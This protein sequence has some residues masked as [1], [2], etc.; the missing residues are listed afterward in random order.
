MSGTISSSLS[1][2]NLSHTRGSGRRTLKK[3]V[4][5]KKNDV[6]ESFQFSNS[7]VQHKK[8]EKDKKIS[9]Y[10][11][12]LHTHLKW[13]CRLHK[14][15]II[16][17]DWIPLSNMALIHK[18][19][20]LVSFEAS[21]DFKY[22]YILDNSGT[23]WRYSISLKSI[24]NNSSDYPENDSK[25]S[26][27]DDQFDNQ[28]TV[29]KKN[30]YKHIYAD[31]GYDDEELD[32]GNNDMLYKSILLNET[33][34]GRVLDK[35]D[36]IDIQMKSQK[37]LNHGDGSSL[38][39]VNEDVSEFG[40]P[41]GVAINKP[42]VSKDFQGKADGI[43]FKYGSNVLSNTDNIE[44]NWDEVLRLGT[45]VSKDSESEIPVK[46]KKPKISEKNVI[47]ESLKNITKPGDWTP[48]TGSIKSD[49]L[50][51]IKKIDG[52]R[53]HKSIKKNNKS[54]FQ[55]VFNQYGEQ[56]ADDDIRKAGSI[57]NIHQESNLD[58]MN[59]NDFDEQVDNKFF[60]T[61]NYQK[62]DTF[63]D[64]PSIFS[65]HKIMKNIE[66]Q[67]ENDEKLDIGAIMDEEKSENPES[68]KMSN[69]R[70]ESKN[71]E[72]KSITSAPKEND[73]DFKEPFRTSKKKIPTKNTE[74][75][76]FINST[77]TQQYKPALSSITIS[78]DNKFILVGLSSGHLRQYSKS[79][80][81]IHIYPHKFL[82]PMILKSTKDGKYFFIGDRSG[83]VSQ[84]SIKT[85]K[86]IKTF[87]AEEHSESYMLKESGVTDLCCT[88]DSQFLFIADEKGYLKQVSIK[89]RVIVKN[90][91]RLTNS[92]RTYISALSISPNS[93]YLQTGDIDGYVKQFNVGKM[94]KDGDYTKI[95]DREVVSIC[96]KKNSDLCFTIDT[97]GIMN[98][99]V[100]RDKVIQFQLNMN[101]DE[102]I[103]RMSSVEDDQFIMT[104]EGNIHCYPS[105]PKE[106][107]DKEQFYQ[108]H[109]T[110]NTHHFGANRMELITALDCSVD[111]KLFVGYDHGK[112]QEY[113]MESGEL[114]KDYG[115]INKERIV[116]VKCL[117]NK[118]FLFSIDDKGNMNQF[119]LETHLQ[120]NTYDDITGQSHTV[121]CLFGVYSDKFLF[122]GTKQGVLYQFDVRMEKVVFNYGNF[123]IEKNNKHGN[124]INKYH[125]FYD[126]QSMSDSKILFCSFGCG[127]IIQINVDKFEHAITYESLDF[128]PVTCITLTKDDKF[129]LCG[130]NRGN[131][132]QFY[133]ENDCIYNG[134]VL[135]LFYN[136]GKVHENG[137][138]SII[139]FEGSKYACSID[140]Q[141]TINYY[142][143]Q[144]AIFIK[145]F[146]L[147]SDVFFKKVNLN[148]TYLITSKLAISHDQKRLLYAD[149]TNKITQIFIEECFIKDERDYF[150]LCIDLFSTS[151]IFYFHI[152]KDINLF[153]SILLKKTEESFTSKYLYENLKFYMVKYQKNILKV[154]KK[155]NV[156]S[157]YDI[158]TMIF[159][160]DYLEQHD[161]ISTFI[162]AINQNNIAKK[163]EMTGILSC[164]NISC[165]KNNGINLMKAM[166]QYSWVKIN[167][168]QHGTKELVQKGF[169]VSNKACLTPNIEN[170]DKEAFQL[171]KLAVPPI[172]LDVYKFNLGMNMNL[173]GHEFNEYLINL[174]KYT[175]HD[176]EIFIDM[177]FHNFLNYIW[178]KCYQRQQ[179]LELAY[180]QLPFVGFCI[181]AFLGDMHESSEYCP[182]PF[183]SIKAGF[184]ISIIALNIPQII[185]LLVTWYAAGTKFWCSIRNIISVLSVLAYI[186]SCIVFLLPHSTLNEF[187]ILIY[188]NAL[189]FGTLKLYFDLNIINFMRQFSY[190]FFRILS[191]IKAF[192]QVII[193]FL[194][195]FN[196]IFYVSNFFDYIDADINY[197]EYL[198]RTYGIFF[199]QWETPHL[200]NNSFTGIV[201]ILFTILFPII[202]FNIL[203]AM[204][205]T[206][207]QES[208][209]NE[210]DNDGKIVLNLIQSS[211]DK[212]ILINDKICKTL[213]RLWCCG[214]LRKTIS[215]DF[216]GNVFLLLTIANVF[217]Y[218]IFEKNTIKYDENK[219]Q[220]IEQQKIKKVANQLQSINVKNTKMIKKL[221]NCK[222]SQHKTAEKLD[223]SLSFGNFFLKKIL[224]HSTDS[225]KSY[226]NTPVFPDTYS[227][228]SRMLITNDK[229]KPYQEN[230][231]LQNIL[232]D[233]KGKLDNFGEI[234]TNLNRLDSKISKSK[235][236]RDMINKLNDKVG[237]T[238]GL[239]KR[240]DDFEN[241][242]DRIMQKLNQKGIPFNKT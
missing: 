183:Q 230:F 69:S 71:S 238:I 223:F 33:N 23:I 94:T 114:L 224:A 132:A 116:A 21:V 136:Y 121:T 152:I 192:F 75:W 225:F 222:R 56:E 203:I 165:N 36:S 226:N 50:G 205:G 72:N 124:V 237:S 2:M 171:P 175:V 20:K 182:N 89:E 93:K 96:I 90:Y 95:H 208:M 11:K 157:K 111:N 134:K 122:I 228:V 41:S 87:I 68:D 81:L 143:I 119:D 29:D 44:N 106:L 24:L 169:A 113:D 86:L 201:F 49:I 125:N 128:F 241:N 209:Q 200:K 99:I 227:P 163:S 92:H 177:K 66:N 197:L 212:K 217:C 48:K 233:I 1:S 39:N 26:F 101:L 73:I 27:I 53:T 167:T 186:V 83:N 109:S 150:P 43:N 199:S 88:A 19:I 162:E 15:V 14:G 213:C 54:R 100:L 193:I 214:R 77:F 12:L 22:Q 148:K 204:V 190:K 67:H 173:I 17:E 130:N 25:S 103:C 61:M 3:L 181:I 229:D 60:Q 164:I 166:S 215:E 47:F 79:Q 242:L 65:K 153:S 142:N 45:L 62:K 78:G 156:I 138:N 40:G 97:L 131:L 137:F 220:K 37:N 74:E 18:S 9:Q 110:D 231:E 120:Y 234:K 178:D 207:Y 8:K 202:I 210:M 232:V 64:K 240:I 176:H 102:G 98:C 85:R 117:Y 112:V 28:D 16:E 194:F 198:L 91:G 10:S 6:L 188:T 32:S 206:S 107:V 170:F 13:S 82:P 38:W 236:L 168:L 52:D 184:C 42:T 57:G 146:N 4:Y 70:E 55:K 185:K 35:L 174:E 147:K 239:E 221:D 58:D 127:H 141:G 63:T 129:Q 211:V 172:E 104:S 235:K 158:M 160:Y 115:K 151:S 123:E 144:D 133:L 187:A 59:L 140:E 196:Q 118:K 80:D 84:F 126:L 195:G 161:Y 34:S 180:S 108:K 7:H 191:D 154:Y 219:M 159:A 189:T 76:L 30:E 135:E 149:N 46:Q 218:A 51:S 5:N 31:A 145:K 105:Y 139:C 216:E 155:V 179:L